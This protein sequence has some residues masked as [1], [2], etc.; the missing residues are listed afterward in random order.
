MRFFITLLLIIFSNTIFAQ[1]P[2]ATAAVNFDPIV[3]FVNSDEKI[4]DEDREKVSY[5][6]LWYCNDGES[7]SPIKE[8]KV[9]T[10]TS[11]VA[12]IPLTPKDRFCYYQYRGTY[13]GVSGKWSKW[14]EKS[15]TSSS[16]VRILSTG[17]IESINLL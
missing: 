5:T 16:N 6:F 2:T 8:H 4:K 15:Y 9:Q 14:Y 12:Y 3:S 11:T 17:R 13:E 7:D 1:Q 10:S